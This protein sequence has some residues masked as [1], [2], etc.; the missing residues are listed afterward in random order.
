MPEIAVRNFDFFTTRTSS[1]ASL[2]LRRLTGLLRLVISLPCA[3]RTR[4]DEAPTKLP[5]VREDA[6]R[7]DTHDRP[8]QGAA[9][10]S[11]TGATTA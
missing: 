9:N 8:G 7:L 4:S 10:S 6:D 2:L 3:H 5:A 1:T 11:G